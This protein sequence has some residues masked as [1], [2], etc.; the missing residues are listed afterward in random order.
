MVT[1]KGNNGFTSCS[2]SPP[3]EYLVSAI[4]ASGISMTR[5]W[6]IAM[7]GTRYCIEKRI[8]IKRVVQ[9]AHER[10]GSSILILAAS[11]PWEYLS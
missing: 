10:T 1:N 7:I 3:V 9:I 8:T 4:F 11:I 5:P 6:K 2:T